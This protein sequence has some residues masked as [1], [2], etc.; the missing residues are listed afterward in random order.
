MQ[1]LYEPELVPAVAAAE[2]YLIHALAYEVQAQ[3]ARPDIF[4]RAPAHLLRIRC[5]SVI[6]QHD[7]KRVTRLATFRRINPV[8]GRID[9]LLGVSKVGV[10]NDVGQRFV[11]GTNHGA[12]I[13]L[14]KS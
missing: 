8:E 5:H 3:A 7:F 12:A 2:F 9:G 11:D 6:F 10:A 14:R 1:K 4:E 13:L